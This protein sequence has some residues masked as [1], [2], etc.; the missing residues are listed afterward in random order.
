[1][2]H[3]TSILNR[4]SQ[5]SNIR[6]H[7]TC[8]TMITRTRLHPIHRPNILSDPLTPFNLLPQ[9][10][11]TSHT[12]PMILSHI[13]RRPT[14]PTTSVRRTRPQLR[15]RLTTSRIRLNL[16][17]LLRNYIQHKGRHTN[18]NRKQP[19]SM[20][21][22]TITRIMIVISHFNITSLKIATSTRTAL[23]KEQLKTNR[24]R[25]N[26]LLSRTHPVNSQ[27]VVR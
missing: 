4:S 11:S 17:N 26:R 19:R 23:L 7:L 1:M 12:S 18:M 25:Q 22:R 2:I 27:R 9:R 20:Q 13:R 15:T 14:P 16:L 21:M 24:N 5:K 3:A 10:D 6:T 8:I